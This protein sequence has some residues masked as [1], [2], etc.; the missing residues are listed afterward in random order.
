MHES[1]KIANWNIERIAPSLQ[2]A[3]VVKERISSVGADI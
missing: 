1:L 3:I 2:R